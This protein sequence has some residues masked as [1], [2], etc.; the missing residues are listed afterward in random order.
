MLAKDLAAIL[1][2]NLDNYVIIRD[3]SFAEPSLLS[4]LEV[5]THPNAEK[6]ETYIEATV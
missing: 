2:Q 1:M 4:V 5:V 3:L 6:C